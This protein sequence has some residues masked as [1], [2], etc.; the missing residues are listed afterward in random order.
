MAKPAEVRAKVRK[1]Y[2]F[3]RL[4]LEQ[5]AKL[6]GVTYSTAKRWKTKAEETGDGWDKLFD[7]TGLVVDI[8]HGVPSV[9][10]NQSIQP[11]TLLLQRWN[12]RATS[13][14]LFTAF[15]PGCRVGSVPHPTIR[16]ACGC[17]V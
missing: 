11:V 12:R 16:F 13:I 7:N 5:A 15:C 4:S 8:S 6:A 2:V 14:W 1:H 9:L 10:S 17:A 3:D